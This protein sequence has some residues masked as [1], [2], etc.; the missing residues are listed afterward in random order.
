M[1]NIE[2]NGLTTLATMGKY[3]PHNVE[4]NINVHEMEDA[5]VG[6]T[7]TEYTN[8]TAEKVGA[9]AFRN[10]ST[11]EKATFYNIK[12]IEQGAF[13]GCTKLNALI[14]YTNEVCKLSNPNAIINTITIY[15][16]EELVNTYK[17]ATNWITYA[18]NINAIS[19][20]KGG[21]NGN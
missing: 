12:T 4:I 10:Y 18:G 20:I 9:Q 5:L 17:T 14:I 6:R 7:L 11:L 3:C 8:Y 2:K 21:Q 1:I 16:P 19:D 15:V 13:M